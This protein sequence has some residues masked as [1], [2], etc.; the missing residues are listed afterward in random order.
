MSLRRN[1]LNQREI[2]IDVNVAFK[3]FFNDIFIH[4]I[5]LSIRLLFRE[6]SNNRTHV[7]KIKNVYC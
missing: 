7:L 4:N 5:K 3:K 6:V 1:F 2:T